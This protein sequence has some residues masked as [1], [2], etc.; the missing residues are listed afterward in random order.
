[1]VLQLQWCYRCPAWRRWGYPR[2]AVHPPH[3]STCDST[4]CYS[5]VTVVLQWCHRDVTVVSQWFYFNVI[6]CYSGL[7]VVLLGCECTRPPA[8]PSDPCHS[9]AT[10]QPVGSVW[11]QYGVTVVSH[12]CCSGVNVV[13]LW[14][15]SGGT[16]VLQRS[17]HTHTHGV[18]L[19]LPHPTP[20][21]PWL[22]P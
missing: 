10:S 20:R 9:E 18:T 13:S 21:S 6:C 16:E 5:G 1:V 3:A 12:W 7:T 2:T 14:C 15:H 4:W 8:D 22:V 17:T 19:L 11:R